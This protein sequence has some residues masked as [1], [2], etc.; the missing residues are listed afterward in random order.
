MDLPQSGSGLDD[1]DGPNKIALRD[2]YAL[3][4]LLYKLQTS[5]WPLPAIPHLR[6]SRPK[7]HRP[8]HPLSSLDKPD[9]RSGKSKQPLVPYAF[10]QGWIKLHVDR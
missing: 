2:T 10:A 9:P 8:L 6:A 1:F 3:C 7:L 4:N 5:S